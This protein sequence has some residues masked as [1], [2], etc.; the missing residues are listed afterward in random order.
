MLII[1]HQTEPELLNFHFRL[2]TDN[3][4]TGPSSGFEV[5]PLNAI[6]VHRVPKARVGES[7]RGG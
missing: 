2:E 3:L 6:G 7:T 5:R 1:L 4:L